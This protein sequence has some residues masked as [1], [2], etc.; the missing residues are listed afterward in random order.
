MSFPVIDYFPVGVGDVLNG[1]AV[2]G[3]VKIEN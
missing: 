3:E 2:S 1:G